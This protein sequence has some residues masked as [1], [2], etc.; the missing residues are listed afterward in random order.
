MIHNKIAILLHFT[1]VLKVTNTSSIEFTFSVMK[2]VL[3]FKCCIYFFRIWA[4]CPI[5]V[6]GAGF[7]IISNGQ[8]VF[9][10]FHEGSHNDFRKLTSQQ[11]P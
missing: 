2:K 7:K 1:Q 8:M 6:M 5:P 9:Y 10:Q 3:H 11:I 4:S